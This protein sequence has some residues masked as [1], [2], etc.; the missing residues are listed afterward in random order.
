[1][2]GA[3]SLNDDLAQGHL[4]ILVHAAA[5]T[6]IGQ[7]QGFALFGGN[8]RIVNVH[9]TKVIDHNHQPQ[10]VIFGQQPIDQ[11][12]FPCTQIAAQHRDWQAIHLKR[13][14]RWADRM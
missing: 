9:R 7:R 8:Q 1:M 12:G 4:Q 11:G 13:V 6:A 5:D 2:I 10:A 14:Q 3:I